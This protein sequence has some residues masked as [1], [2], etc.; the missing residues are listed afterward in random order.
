VIGSLRG[1]ILDRATRGDHSG[2]VLLE[3]GGVGY[4]VIVPGSTL[5]RIGE[6]GGPAFV[7]VHTHVREDAIILY[8]FATRDERA[9]FEALIGAHGVGPAVALALLS[10][11][12]PAALRR[13]VAT[14]DLDALMLVPGIGRKTAARLLI[15]LKARLDV[16]LDE[17]DLTVV[18]GLGRLPG[19]G[20][21]RAEVRAALAG[22][23]Y[24]HDEVREVLAG[25][26]AEGPV[27][28]M[29]RTALR[30]LAGAR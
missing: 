10:V 15:E 11:H 5:A 19:H 29:L 25:L 8:G 12:A 13:A 14:D 2:E 27:E 28:E 22:L 1:V 24:G 9:S 3:V 4:R 30:Q 26:P 18:G 16:D 6:L 20:G 21:P 23:G 17:P 7:H